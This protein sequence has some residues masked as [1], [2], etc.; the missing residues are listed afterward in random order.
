MKFISPMLAAPMPKKN[1]SM[2]PGRYVAEEKYDGHRL[3]VA[4]S[5]AYVHAWARSGIT[6]ALPSVLVNQLAQLPD[7]TYDGE[8]IVPG[9]K[10]HN[11][12]ELAKAEE[13]QYAMFDVMHIGDTDAMRQPYHERRQVLEAI[14]AECGVGDILDQIALA[15]T[16]VINYLGEIDLLKE[17]IWARGGEGLILKDIHAPYSPGKRPK[18]V[19]IKIKALRST[20]IKIIGF[21]RGLNGPYAKVVG[22]DDMGVRVTVKTLNNA[23]LDRCARNPEAVIG[24][25]LRI[26]YQEPTE[27]E[28]YRHPR[29]DRFEDE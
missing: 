16:S 24:R 9:G 27:N 23:E 17:R 5:G 29:W 10:S 3:V 28:K 12:V 7:G 22:V 18:G 19:W 20:T 14:K 13:L 2:S 4:V 15:E 26:E 6:R 11:V 1:W 8:L 25:V 21:A